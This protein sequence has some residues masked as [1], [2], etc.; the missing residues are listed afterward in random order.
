MKLLYYITF[1][2]ICSFI[3]F[4]LII[5]SGVHGFERYHNFVKELSSELQKRQEKNEKE[6]QENEIEQTQDC[7]QQQRKTKIFVASDDQEVKET[8]HEYSDSS[9]FLY[10]FFSEFEKK[11]L[12]LHKQLQS[13]INA[14]FLSFLFLSFIFL[15]FPFLPLTIPSSF[16]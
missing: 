11:D 15:P 14:G 8:A 16:F 10:D 13:N 9:A 3:Y 7:Q 2:V 12:G 5:F 6:T 4:P 1:F